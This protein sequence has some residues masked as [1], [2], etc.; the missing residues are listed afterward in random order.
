MSCDS[1][2]SQDWLVKMDLK[3][4]YLQCPST[5]T[6][7]T[8][9]LFSG[10]GR[11]TRSNWPISSTQSVYKAA[12]ASSGLPDTE[13][14]SSDHIPG[15]LMHQDRAQLE[16][17]TRLTCQ[18]FKSLGLIVN[19]KKSILTPTQEIDFLGFH[20]CSTTMRASIPTEKLHKIQQDEQ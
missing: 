13:W 17:I 5:Q 16:Q 11:Y 10:K 20:L 14:L 7:N 1:L 8:S 2:Q 12:E 9:S 3:D 19:Q 6:I 4:A 18:L 15:L